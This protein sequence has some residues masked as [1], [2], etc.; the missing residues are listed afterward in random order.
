[1]TEPLRNVEL[2]L[3]LVKEGKV[4]EVYALGGDLLLVATDRLSAFDVVLD[5]PIPH[6]GRVLT[7]LSLWWFARTSD[8]VANHLVTANADEI[9]ERHPPLAGSR[10]RWEGRSMLCRETEPFPIECVVRGY[11]TGSA[12]KEYRESGTLAGEPL[13]AGLVEAQ[14]LDPPIFSPATKASEGHDENITFERACVTVGMAVANTLR[15]MSLNLYR[16]AHDIAAEG[17]V[18]LADT[19][20]EFGVG[21]EGEILLIDEIL[22]PDSSRFWLVD[23][24]EPGHSQ[25]SFDKQPVRDYLDLLVAKGEWNRMPPPPTLPPEVVE[26]TSKRYLR[27]YELITG[28]A[29]LE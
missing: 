20:F 12:W 25:Q 21:K 7:Q 29:P 16:R 22:T 9:I 2:D 3:P 5:E 4:R 23:Q 18:I 15:E 14:R 8:I 17:G 19:K 28:E 6:K 1:M 26:N 11:I 10:D 27:A 13:P 24:Y